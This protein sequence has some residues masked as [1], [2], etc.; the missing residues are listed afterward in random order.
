MP[1]YL[2]RRLLQIGPMLL[3]LLTLTFILI[4]LAPG[5]PVVALSGEF[6]TAEYQRELE[7]R[8]GLDRPL[9]ERYLR[10][11]GQVLQGDLGVSY[12]YK[13]P[14]LEVILARL[15][16]TLLLVLPAV[17][18]S[19]GLGIWLGVQAA[20][21]PG[22]LSDLGVNVATLTAFAIPVFWLAQLLV[23][24]LAV[25]LNWFPVQ[26][27]RNVRANYQGLQ[28]WLDVAWHLTLPV[29]TMTLH[30]LA[31]TT[32]LT[33][34]GMRNEMGQDYVRTARAKGLPGRQVLYGHALR[35]AL[36]PV[37]TVIGGR[38]GFLLAGAVLTETVFA[39]PG[40]GRLV[41]SASLNRDYPVVLGLFICISLLVLLANLV[42]D[43][44]YAWLDPRIRYS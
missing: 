40:L 21:R 6:S 22:S 5:G 35:N 42:T 30:Q 7:A 10:Y 3:G 4:H 2:L 34:A 25:H 15:P 9:P 11:L 23:L 32:A 14:V 39:W 29:L 27:M 38:V 16:A 33:R 12:Y 43:L 24:L 19:S 1:S 31:L 41:V 37:V 28:L 44:V 18:I 13:T 36:L 17:T 26:G 8:Y 20:R